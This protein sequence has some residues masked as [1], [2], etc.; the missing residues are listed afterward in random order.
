MDITLTHSQISDA[1][2]AAYKYALTVS[3]GENAH[4]IPYL[5]NIDLDCS[6]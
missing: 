5:A 2:E 3:G 6:G 4:Y 1:A